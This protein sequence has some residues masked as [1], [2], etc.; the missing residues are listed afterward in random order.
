M[1]ASFPSPD[2]TRDSLRL[3]EELKEVRA[4]LARETEARARLERAVVEAAEKEQHRLAQT[5][6]DTVCQSL[7]GIDLMARVIARKLQASCPEGARDLA[8]LADVVHSAVGELHDVSRWLRPNSRDTPHLLP[9]LRELAASAAKKCVCV[10]EIPKV[11]AMPNRYA[12]VQLFQIAQE[13]VGNALRHSDARQVT[14]SLT[15]K[16]GQVQLTVRDDGRGIAPDA[17]AKPIG[18]LAMLRHRARAMNA[19]LTISSQPGQGTTVTC[20]LPLAS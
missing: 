14:I 12:A 5:L 16:K 10:L 4:A 3:A 8:E 19:E 13:A 2:N 18:G 7:S 11:L 17:P 9:A 15:K 20:G 6:H 1:S